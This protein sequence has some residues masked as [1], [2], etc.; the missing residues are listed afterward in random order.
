MTRRPV[1]RTTTRAADAAASAPPRL[2]RISQTRDVLVRRI[3]GVATGRRVPAASNA[4]ALHVA[5][6][7]APS[8]VFLGSITS[9]IAPLLLATLAVAAACDSASVASPRVPPAP[10]LTTVRLALGASSIEVGQATTATATAL[11]QYGAPVAT[12]SATY[13]SAAPE[14]AGV[15]PTT[16]AVLAVAPGAAEITAT[17]EGK[18]DQRTVTVVTSPVRLNEVRPNGD[19]PGGWVEFYNPTSADVDM[20]G[21]TVASG[22]LSQSFTIPAQAVIPARGFLAVNEGTLPLGLKAADAVHLFSRFGVQ[23][24]SYSWTVSPPTSYGRCP[25]GDGDFVVTTAP[26]RKEANACPAAAP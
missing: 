14:V 11:D 7:E 16:G 9:A 13:A 26:T 2:R 24:D 4:K 19:L 20:S 25:D 3:A 15:Q 18:S 5:R 23:V 21:W 6:L 1:Q 10:V 8:A 22:D 17:I 12:A